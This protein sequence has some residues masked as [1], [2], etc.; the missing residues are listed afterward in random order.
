MQRKLAKQ[1][2]QRAV[3]PTR[4]IIGWECHTV[5]NNLFS[6]ICADMK[7]DEMAVQHA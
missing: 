5:S 3:R 1:G 4:S 2:V 7:V 6:R